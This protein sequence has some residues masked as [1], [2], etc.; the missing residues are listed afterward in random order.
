MGTITK[1]WAAPTSITI[2]LDSL[3]S[4]TFVESSAVDVSTIDPEDVAICVKVVT[5][6]TAPS[7]S[8]R[9]RVYL[10]VSFDGTSYSTG[11]AGGTTATD[12]PD[13]YWIGDVPCNTASSTHTRAFSVLTAIGFVPPYFKLVCKNELGTALATG[14]SA[15]YTTQNGSY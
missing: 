11:P 15:E 1:P 7:A 2:S 5:T 6:A 14:C 3:A 13:L 4:A 10:K 12:E 9:S 8:L